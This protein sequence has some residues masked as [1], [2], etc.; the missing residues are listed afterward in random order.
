MPEAI[1]P[2]MNRY[3]TLSDKPGGAWPDSETFV[4]R[5]AAALAAVGL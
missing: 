2:P 3:W 4:L 1:I 5:Q